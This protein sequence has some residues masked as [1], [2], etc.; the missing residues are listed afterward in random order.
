M[1]S[2]NR[3]QITHCKTKVIKDITYKN[4]YNYLL[5]KLCNSINV[6]FLITFPYSI[7]GLP[8]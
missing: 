5:I 4:D 6:I 1:V 3:V 8:G 2:E 7:P